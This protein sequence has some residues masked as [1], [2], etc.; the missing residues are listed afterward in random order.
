[1]KNSVTRLKYY[2]F[3]SALAIIAAKI[4]IAMI[5]PSEVIDERVYLPVI[6]PDAITFSEKK[7]SPKAY[8]ALDSYGDIIG[9]CFNSYDIVPSIRGYAGPIKVLVGLKESGEL[10]GIKVVSHNET[11][12][13]MQ[14]LIDDNFFDQF[15]YKLVT[16][17]FI[18]DKDLDGVT[19]ATV[20]A[21][22]IAKS[23]KKSA[24]IVAKSRYGM[25]IP[26]EPEEGVS[27]KMLIETALLFMLTIA[28][29]TLFLTKKSNTFSTMKER[30]KL[31][32]GMRDLLLIAVL[33]FAGFYKSSPISI[34][35]ILNVFY[36]RLPEA[37]NIYFYILLGG[38]FVITLLFGRVYC[39]YLCPFGAL[40]EF[41]EKIRKKKAPAYDNSLGIIKYIFLWA[42]LII[43]LYFDRVEI[44]SF[45][46]YLALFSASGNVFMWV[47]LT[48][49]LIFSLFHKR[50]WCRYFCAVGA[51]SAIITK[52]APFKTAP[53]KSC[54]SCGA[55]TAICPV[56]ID[57]KNIAQF[58]VEECI[59]CRK[60]HEYCRSLRMYP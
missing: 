44:S 52:L 17:D 29:V 3:I 35:N 41:V 7:S 30:N 2:L 11:K 4:F 38:F 13:Y 26:I 23:V 25:S 8:F 31:F 20:S 40:T 32:T 56:E 15:S 42:I 12:I 60:C 43:V 54:D 37:K 19:H 33:A 47:A 18:L 46:P 36:L 22:A 24:A 57:F 16:D 28:A 21:E 39:G 14:K 5:T 50:F 58:P 51:F 55:C 49:I 45:E 1:M 59:A 34:T 10:S 6:F 48:L 9:Y 53:P 27:I